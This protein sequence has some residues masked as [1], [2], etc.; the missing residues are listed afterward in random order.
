MVQQGRRRVLQGQTKPGKEL[1]LYLINKQ[2]IAMC[3]KQT[4][5][6]HHFFRPNA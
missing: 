4:K 1:V 3:L 6:P 2:T 5:L